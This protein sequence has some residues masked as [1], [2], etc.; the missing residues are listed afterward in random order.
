MP[1]LDGKKFKY[2]KEGMEEYQKALK[3]K[4]DF[5]VG[6]IS[7]KK[8]FTLKK[9]NKKYKMKAYIKALRKKRKEYEDAPGNPQ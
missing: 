5:K 4:A 8:P 6:V 2:D 1:K 7:H 9:E 3:K